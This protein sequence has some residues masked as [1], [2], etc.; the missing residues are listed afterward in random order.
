MNNN[1][2]IFLN[3]I[4]T[5]K[6]NKSTNPITI[7]Q[8]RTINVLKFVDV[9]CGDGFY[10]KLVK[11]VHPNAKTIGVEKEPSY[12]KKWD[13]LSIYDE[14]ICD[15]IVNIIS[16]LTGDLIIFGD[17]L[18]H[19]EKEDVNRVIDKCVNNFSYIIINAPLGFQ[20]QEHEIESE[21]NRCGLSKVDF[22]RFNILSY[23]EINENG[24]MF[25]CFIKG[26]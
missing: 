12:I 21:I 20:P 15:D 8:I 2:I 16:D 19:L 3:S 10:G 25:N 14:V 23:V 7:E 26:I 13:L 22:E 6:H 11:Y 17:V 4:H 24:L 18:E 9:G 1:D 5:W